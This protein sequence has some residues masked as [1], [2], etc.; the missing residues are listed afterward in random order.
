MKRLS[1]FGI[2]IVLFI[3]LLGTLFIGCQQQPAPAQP[4]AQAHQVENAAPPTPT[5]TPAAAPELSEAPTPQP[6]P[7]PKPTPPSPSP[8]S[9]KLIALNVDTPEVM[10][11]NTANITGEVKNLGGIIGP[12]TLC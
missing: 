6:T 2:I 11:G 9:F 5:S 12:L 4:E 8:A 7:A 1:I 10:A 3:S